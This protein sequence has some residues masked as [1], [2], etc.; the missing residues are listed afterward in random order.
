M[1]QDGHTPDRPGLGLSVPRT[2]EFTLREG[3]RFHN[4]DPFTAEDVKF[5]FLRYRGAASKLLKERVKSV[6]VVDRHRVR[7]VL[8]APWPDFLAFHEQYW[9]KRPS[10]KRIVIKGVPDRTTRLAMLKTGEADIATGTYAYGGYP[11]LDDLFPQAGPGARPQEARGDPASGPAADARAGH[12]C[13]DLRAGHAARGGS[14]GG[15]ARGRP[16][17]PAVLR[18]PLRGYAL[19]EPVGGRLGVSPA[20]AA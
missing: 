10:V 2:Y 6:D 7:F 13:A 20:I 17:P 12:A 1:E 9:R 11:D 15:G 3:L 18:R 16:E 5:S 8:H 19:E 14:P 4:G